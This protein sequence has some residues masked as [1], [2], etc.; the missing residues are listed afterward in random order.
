MKIPMKHA[1]D[2][3]KGMTF[4]VVFAMMAY[5][6]T[7]TLAAWIYLGLHGSYGL[8]WVLKSN[9]YPDPN[10]EVR[11][12]AWKAVGVWV[13]LLLYWLAPY[14]LI[15]GGTEA[16]GWLVCLAITMNVVGSVFHYGSDAQKYFVLKA[17]KGLIT[18]GFFARTRNP[19]YLGEMLIYASF[20]ALSMHWLPWVVCAVYW[21]GVFVPNM[22]RKDKSMSRYDEWDSYTARSWLVIPKPF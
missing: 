11:L 1:V 16:P 22:L 2:L 15:S 8:M 5:F 18:T 10:W 9:T 14:L 13:A 7:W 6:D 12:P 21:L 4:P 20:A 17:R 19:N 3:H